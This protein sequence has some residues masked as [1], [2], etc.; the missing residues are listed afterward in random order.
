MTGFIAW[1]LLK[2]AVSHDF[3]HSDKMYVL[4]K[5]LKLLNVDM[6]SFRDSFA[7]LSAASLAVISI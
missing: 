3:C 4:M 2:V 5:G 7:F 6:C 1:S